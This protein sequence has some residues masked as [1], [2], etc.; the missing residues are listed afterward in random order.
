MAT[1]VPFTVNWSTYLSC[2]WE[3]VL[4]EGLKAVSNMISVASTVYAVR[5]VL[6]VDFLMA[7]WRSRRIP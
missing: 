4:V 3:L 7:G 1:V 5:T 6:L 2:F